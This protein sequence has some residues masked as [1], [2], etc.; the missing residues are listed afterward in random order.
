M[1]KSKGEGSIM[2]D[3]DHIDRPKSILFI[4]ALDFWSLGKG[5]GRP[6]F[7]RT[8]TGYADQGCEVAT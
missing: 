3:R 6:A 5:K 2:N 4:S 7:L 1:G 8:L